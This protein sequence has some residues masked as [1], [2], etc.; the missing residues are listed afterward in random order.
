MWVPVSPR[1]SR[2]RRARAGAAAPR[3]EGVPAVDRDRDGG[4]IDTS[5]VSSAVNQV[6]SL[7]RS[8]SG[9][10]QRLRHVR[11]QR[12]RPALSLVLPARVVDVGVPGSSA[13][14][15]P[16]FDCLGVALPLPLRGARQRA[17]PGPLAVQVRGEGADELPDDA[18]NLVVARSWPS[19]ADGDGLGV[20]IDN[21]LPLAAG[22]GSSAAAIV[23]GLAAAD[24][25]AQRPAAIDRERLY[26]RAVGHRGPPRQRRGERHRR[27]HDRRRRPAAGA[28]HRAARGLGLRARR[29]ARAAGDA[30][31][32]GPRWPSRSP[33]PRRPERAARRAAGLVAL[34]RQ[35][36]RPVGRAVRPA[37]RDAR[38]HLVP[39]FA[40][41][42]AAG[43]PHRRARRDAVRRRPERAASGAARPTSSAAPSAWPARSPPSSCT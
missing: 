37:A 30:A 13:N 33:A 5:D 17:R 34:H 40:R 19:G 1:S 14:L 18:S 4:P 23:A 3:P 15:G 24:A 25:P 42:A 16:G 2:E 29:A 22:C 8:R 20:E 35:R 32:P 9:G 10:Y 31:R 12:G 6:A 21:E 11:R 39:T 27:L 28:P 41:L 36:R 43:R 38:A 26:A 7:S